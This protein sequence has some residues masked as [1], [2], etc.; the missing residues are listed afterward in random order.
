MNFIK[1][2]NIDFIDLLPFY[3]R[4]F[5]A[6]FTPSK[7]WIDLDNYRNDPEGLV[8][9]CKKWRTKVEYRPRGKNKIYETMVAMGG[10]Y[11]CH[12]RQ[13]SLY[14]YE[15]NLKDFKF[16]DRTW[17]RFKFKFMQVMMHEMI[18]FMQYD[19]RFDEPTNYVLPYKKV[20][21][22]KVDEERRYLSDF[23]EIQAY[24]HCVYLDLKCFHP[25]KTVKDLSVKS[26]RSLSHTLSYYL[27]T[28]DKD[29]RNNEAINKLLQQV[30]KWDSK[31]QNAKVILKRK[32][33]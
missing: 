17:A 5:R 22:V 30:C 13:M 28:F 11:D 1:N 25:S 20:G 7:I 6:K 31:Y 2:L 21:K 19:R 29:H 3:E 26:K 23:D 15:T 24:A 18:H 27:K 12:D 4:P 10:E 16:T 8:H 9:Y 14:V 33:K 32:G